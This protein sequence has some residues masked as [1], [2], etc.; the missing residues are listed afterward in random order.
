M[1]VGLVELIIIFGIFLGILVGLAAMIRA[2]RRE[3]GGRPEES[4]LVQELSQ[5]LH[6]MEERIEALETLLL[7][8][9]PRGSVK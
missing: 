6:T 8:R 5:G 1:L 7:E 3:P 2:V 9:E 4:Q